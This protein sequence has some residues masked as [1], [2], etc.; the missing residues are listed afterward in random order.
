MTSSVTRNSL[1]MASGTIVSRLLGLLRTALLAG[2]I[3]SQATA[4]T[5]TVANVLPNIIFL[6]ISGGVLDSVLVPQ[7]VKAARDPDH[8]EEFTNRLLTLATTGMLAVAVVSTLLAPVLITVFAP[9]FPPQMHSLA[10]SFAIICLP[11]VFFYGIYALIGQVLNAH[12][13]LTAFGWAPAAANVV[14]IAGL[15]VFPL[16]YAV[17]QPP[18]AWSTGMIWLLAGSQ[19]L[20]IV[21]QAGVTVLAAWRAGVRF[22]PV[23][24]LRGVGLRTTSSLA[25]W[26]FAA[27][28]VSQGGYFVL[29]AVLSRATA[30]GHAA[31]GL[32]SY[33]MLLFMLPHSLVALSIVTALYPRISSH[34]HSGRFRAVRRE[35]Y[36]G[37]V[38]PAGA[39][40]PAMVGWM[41]ISAPATEV[42]FHQD[43]RANRLIA[44]T[45]SIMLL[46]IVPFGINVLNQRFL[47]ALEEG[48][49]AFRVQLVLTGTSTTIYL[50]SL[51]LDSG[52]AVALSAVAL[53]VS[54]LVGSVAGAWWVRRRIG[55]LGVAQVIRSLAKTLVASLG[56]ALVSWPA[57][58]G[59]QQLLPDNRVG[60]FVVVVVVGS[61]F[62]VAYLAWV[63][64]LRIADLVNVADPFLRRVP[65]L[66]RL[67]G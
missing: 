17:Q 3:A 58:A 9:S 65:L 10:V 32:Q 34:I 52:Y 28:L 67:T 16:L 60:N 22:R 66:R 12:G 25:G 39:T 49:T 21:V 24:G 59:M 50:G 30:A 33:A 38:V 27:L 4:D 43:A 40:V 6:V 36:R 48:R 2:V 15:L 64:L 31:L 7:L 63:Y 41:L 14:Q 29:S 56:A 47:Y 53:V 37:I 42:M 20:S 55:T 23:W 46:G 11:Q 1:G 13:R 57:L 45:A 35:Y 62:A 26:A 19:T 61:F 51:L 8:G 54:N 5:F 18:Q 44:L